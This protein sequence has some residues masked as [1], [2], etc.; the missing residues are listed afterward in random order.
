MHQLVEEM[1]HMSI[2]SHPKTYGSNAQTAMVPTWNFEVNSLQSTQLKNCQ[3][4][5]GKNK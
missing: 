4:P 2:S 5:G 1:G 3:W